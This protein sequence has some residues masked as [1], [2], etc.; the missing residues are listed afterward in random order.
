[1]ERG[2]FSGEKGWG[3]SFSFPP[4]NSTPRPAT[5]TSLRQAFPSYVFNFSFLVPFG[6]PSRPPVLLFFLEPSASPSPFSLVPPMYRSRPHVLLVFFSQRVFCRL[7]DVRPSIPVTRHFPPPPFPERPLL[8]PRGTGGGTA[9]IFLLFFFPWDSHPSSS[10]A[11]RPR[12]SGTP[13]LPPSDVFFPFSFL[14]LGGGK[15]SFFF[16][17]AHQCGGILSP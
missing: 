7:G 12:G 17:L 9:A 10:P 16:I 2:F 4:R 13:R 3:D 5:A 15:G 14:R 8:D 6:S 1:M 11:P